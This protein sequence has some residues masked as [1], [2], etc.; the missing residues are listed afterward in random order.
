M[1]SC[2]H[3]GSFYDFL[4]HG[5]KGSWSRNISAAHYH[6]PELWHYIYCFVQLLRWKEINTHTHTHTHT[7]TPIHTRTHAHTHT[8]ISFLI[9][10]YLICLFCFIYFVH[11][12]LCKQ[13]FACKSSQSRSTFD[14]SWTYNTKWAHGALLNGTI[15]C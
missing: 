15:F 12:S 13:T 6:W 3:E 10:F 2:Y 4:W 7:H 8:N 11:V 5:G 9:C 14:T 1:Q